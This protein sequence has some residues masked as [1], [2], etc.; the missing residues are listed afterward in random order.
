M[1]SKK[2]T[3]HFKNISDIKDRVKELWGDDYVILED[4]SFEYKN[5]HQHVNF[6][7]NK[8]G[9]T[10]MK[11]INTLLHGYPCKFCSGRY[12]DNSDQMKKFV[13]DKTNG[14]YELISDTYKT[15]EKGLFKHITKDGDHTFEM[16]IHNFTVLRQRCPLCNNQSK[17]IIL[18]K[19]NIRIREYLNLHKI[20]FQTE[21]KLDGCRSEETNNLLSFDIF[22]PIYNLFIEFDGPQHKKPI[23][24]FGG[25]KAFE[26][27][28]KNDNTKNKFIEKSDVYS[29]LRIDEKDFSRIEE[30]LDKTFNDYR[31][32]NSEEKSE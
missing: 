5:V 21:K 30:I 27:T 23:A 20:E 3:K 12:F 28:V 32:D 1:S 6:H 8:C 2:G 4:N 14:E 16:K 15:R 25:Q 7:C 9:N 18:S 11:R 19:G 22:V 29:L 13:T 31:N 17:G 10:Y 26:R 24:Y